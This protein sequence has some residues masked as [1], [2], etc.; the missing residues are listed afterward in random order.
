MLKIVVI[1]LIALT[2]EAIGVVLLSAGLKEI[3]SPEHLTFREVGQVIKRGATN[4]H[5][6]LGIL[7]EAV[8]FAGL[9]YLLSKADVSLVWPLT[10]LGF[11]LTTLSARIYLHEKVTS[12]RWAGVCLIVI[13]AA[14]ITYS[15]QRKSA[16]QP[17]PSESHTVAQSIK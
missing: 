11:V 8:F 16:A 10:S 12:V 2:V 15:E 7:L 4:E 17:S 9:L 5:V 3:G 13:G 1:L 14:L 6:L